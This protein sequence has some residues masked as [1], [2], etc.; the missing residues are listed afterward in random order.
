MPARI[1]HKA[2]KDIE[3]KWCYKCE[4]WEPLYCFGKSER[5]WDKK[6]DICK[7]CKHKK[8]IATTENK[9]LQPKQSRP[10]KH[11]KKKQHIKQPYVNSV[12]F[13]TYSEHLSSEEIQS[14]PKN[15]TLLQVKCTYCGRWINPT[16]SQVKERVS[17]I[18][19]KMFGKCR[20]YC[21]ENCKQACPLFEQEKFPTDFKPATSREVVPLL[22][23]TILKRDNYTCQKCY[24]TIDIAQLHV[25]NVLSNDPGNCIT[26]C[27]DC[28]EKIHSRKTNK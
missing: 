22:R 17:A 12:L 10:K 28:H 7:L 8:Y 11:K 23:Q 14:D 1:E 24:A 3:C 13:K 5:A 19:R 6:A 21:S 25:H 18:N 2:I 26:L 9:K 15:K 16:N 4:Q 27:K 20:F